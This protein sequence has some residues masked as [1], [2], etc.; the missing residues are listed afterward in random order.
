MWLHD[1]FNVS[2]SLL[3]GFTV[4][5]SAEHRPLTQSHWLLSHRHGLLTRQL[6]LPF[7]VA[8]CETF[9]CDGALS[10]VTITPDTTAKENEEQQMKT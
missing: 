2:I 3:A 10:A 5:K 8:A 1:D 6:L 4:C 9:I 7:A